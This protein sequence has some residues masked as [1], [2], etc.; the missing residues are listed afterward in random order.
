MRVMGRAT[1]G[2]TLIRMD[3]DDAIAAVAKIDEEKEEGGEE[4]KKD[5][6][7]ELDV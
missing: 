2:V 5:G 1:Q 6:Q 4:E 7:T 3:K